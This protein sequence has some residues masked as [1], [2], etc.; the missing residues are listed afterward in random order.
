MIVG[1]ENRVL[2]NGCVFQAKGCCHLQN[3]FLAHVTSAPITHRC[4]QTACRRAAPMTCAAAATFA[5][6]AA[7][8]AAAARRAPAASVLLEVM[9]VVSISVAAAVGRRRGA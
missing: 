6:A 3:R 9:L 7:A 5:A 4:R 8:A 2:F 1:A